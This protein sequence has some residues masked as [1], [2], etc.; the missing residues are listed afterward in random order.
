[1]NRLVWLALGTAAALGACGSPAPPSAKDVGAEDAGA[2][3]VPAT[4][5][6]RNPFAAQPDTSEGLT[7]DSTDLNAVL[8]R[9]A[10]AGACAK[11]AAGAHDRRSMLLCGKS[12]FFDEGFGNTGVP[13]A[14]ISFLI[15]N[16]PNEIGFGFEKL[17]M[18][19]DPR[20]AAHFPIGVAPG[21]KF[22]TADTMAFSCASC[23]F[24]RL[25]DGRYSVGAANHSYAYGTQN[26]ALV[27][28]PTL[29][30]R[31]DLTAHDAGARARLKPLLDRLNSDAMLK[32]KLLLA[33]APLATA[34]TP[35]MFPKEIEQHYATWKSGT[36]DFLI[37]PLPFNDHVHTVSKISPLWGI[38]Q[39][40]EEKTYGMP[41]AM[42]GAT[43]GTSSLE[44]FA[45][46]F[47]DLGG[48]DLHA[49]PPALLAPLAE[50]IY[51]LRAPKS[52]APSDTVATANGA[53]LFRDRGCAGCHAGPRGSGQ[54][55]YSFAEVGTD[56]EMLK[57][58]NPKGDGVIADGLRFLPGDTITRQL[59]SPRLTGLWSMRRFLHNGSVDSLE[60]LVCANG[61]RTP[62][63]AP[64]Y[65]NQG[66]TYGC[67]WTAAEKTALLAF[68]RSI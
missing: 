49:W 5:T 54:R 17:G 47:V 7:N 45:A 8:E 37:E 10:L 28:L 48:G 19:A 64:A 4:P 35:P 22:G 23:H 13:K 67:D 12:M 31:G 34:G 50:Y 66:H 24:G 43:G 32:G 21:K 52:T 63:L 42:L 1:M 62:I 25:E 11:Y 58:A 20:S 9:G 6:D 41:S 46:S 44:N 38:P 53:A 3:N 2:Q 14:L 36:M 26:L 40:A 55:F 33:I 59:K 65:G 27:V 16:F 51:S 61:A 15:E 57:W 56:A 68:L 60:D 39:R 18:I 29:A 30:L